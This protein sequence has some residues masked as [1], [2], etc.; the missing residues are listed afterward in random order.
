MSE[1]IVTVDEVGEVKVEGKGFA[2]KSCVEATRELEQA[3]GTVTADTKKAEFYQ[4][5][6][7]GAQQKARG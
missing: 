1:I 2:G 7:A 3:L 4:P 6:S 5:A